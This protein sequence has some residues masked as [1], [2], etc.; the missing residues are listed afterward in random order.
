MP[1]NF[2]RR[3]SKQRH[4]AGY[5][6]DGGRIHYPF[7]PR[8]GETAVVVR[9]QRFQGGDVF[10]VHQLDGTLAHIPC[11]MMSE[12][13]AHHEL[14]SEPR[15]PLEHLRDLRIE[16]DSLL[17]FLRL[18]SKAE[19]VVDEARAGEAASRSVPGRWSADRC[20]QRS[21]ARSGSADSDHVDRDR[22]NDIGVGG[23]AGGRR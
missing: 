3:P 22:D 14:R 6:G 10:V 5:Q 16:V 17:D 2:S 7:H 21:E 15:L 4:T 23:G 9:R 18:D 13:A 19:G 20:A 8:C 1:T 11:W 12:A